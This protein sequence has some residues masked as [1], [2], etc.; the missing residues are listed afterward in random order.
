VQ[1]NVLRAVY[2]KSMKK[3]RQKCEKKEIKWKK[4]GS[5]AGIDRICAE[6]VCTMI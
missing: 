6:N 1:E 3:D 4:M 5:S 2:V